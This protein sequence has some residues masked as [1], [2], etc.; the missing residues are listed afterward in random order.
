MIEAISITKAFWLD[1]F[2]FTKPQMIIK[3]NLTMTSE[4]ILTQ[5]RRPF[6][7][8][9]T[10]TKKLLFDLRIPVNSLQ[11]Q[12]S[13]MKTGVDYTGNVLIPQIEPNV[14][15]ELEISTYFDASANTMVYSGRVDGHQ[16]VRIENNDQIFGN[17]VNFKFAACPHC[18]ITGIEY[19]VDQNPSGKPNIYTALSR[20]GL[21]SESV[22]KLSDV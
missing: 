15:Y 19:N 10:H 22:I 1:K 2:Q 21:T 14:N 9:D 16:V 6:V 3:A 4:E 18:S 13:F 8:F 11:L 20:Y 5:R 12:I 7:L 17:E